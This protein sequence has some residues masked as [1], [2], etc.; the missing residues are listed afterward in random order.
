MCG[1]NVHRHG[2]CVDYSLARRSEHC[3]LMF[4]HL[5]NMWISPTFLFCSLDAVVKLEKGFSHSFETSFS[6]SNDYRLQRHR[7][8]TLQDVVLMTFVIWNSCVS[9]CK[10]REGVK[11]FSLCVACLHFADFSCRSSSYLFTTRDF[12]FVS[13]AEKHEVGDGKILWKN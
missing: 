10:G 3:F 9:F 1:V 2:R 7:H 4:I 11:I 12:S 13:T 5:F 6:L 8:K